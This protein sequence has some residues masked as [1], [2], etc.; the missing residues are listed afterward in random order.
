MKFS[1]TYIFNIIIQ[2]VLD[3]INDDDKVP[4]STL[5]VG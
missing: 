3:T 1:Y 2:L 4:L 5:H